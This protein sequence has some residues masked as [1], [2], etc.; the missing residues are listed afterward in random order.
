MNRR[1]LVRQWAVLLSLLAL[2]G[3]GCTPGSLGW[4]LRDDKAKPE[5]PLPPKAGKKEV[6]VLVITSQAPGLG[7]DPTFSTASRDLAVEI[8]SRLTADTRG[9]KTPIVVI[10]PARLE[11]H[12]ATLGDWRGVNPA[13]IG[14]QLGADYVID[15]NID[16]MSIFQPEDAGEFYAGRANVS[17]T[18]YDTA[19]PEV[20][21]QQYIHNSMQAKKG[22]SGL[23]PA[24]YRAEFSKRLGT[25]I[26]WRH[27]PHDTSERIGKI[28]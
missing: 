24:R 26:A 5:H 17:V 18:V 12:K 1:K 22:V 28:D 3:V 20:A 13:V 15:A 14:Q 27:I 21:Y 11:R 6:A 19:K 4:L 25:E 8:G 23:S 2:A 9:S 7:A 10:D 16:Q